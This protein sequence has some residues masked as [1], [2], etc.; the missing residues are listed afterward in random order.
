VYTFY[1]TLTDLYVTICIT[2]ILIQHIRKVKNVNVA[3]NINLFMA[4]GA[5][6]V[7]R[8]TVLM[9]SN[10]VSAALILI[11]ERQVVIM[12]TWPIINLLFI[13]LVGHDNDIARLLRKLH[14]ATTRRGNS[15]RTILTPD[16]DCHEYN[17]DKIP[18]THSAHHSSNS[19]H[20]STYQLQAT[21][22]TP[23]HTPSMFDEERGP[24][25]PPWEEPSFTPSQV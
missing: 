10:L 15:S 25:R 4:V 13:L 19:N 24:W 9:I 2:T 20:N 16:P 7:M 17:I 3:A 12:I 11:Q 5:T 1:D 22:I 21:N 14:R 8:T 18:S 6:N 23:I